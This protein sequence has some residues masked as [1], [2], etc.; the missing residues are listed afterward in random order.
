MSIRLTKQMRED[1]RDRVMAATT[2][3]V[4]RKEIE[5]ATKKYLSRWLS[6]QIPKAFRDFTKS[7]P[8]S[9]FMMA[10]LARVQNGVSPLYILMS[11]VPNSDYSSRYI[12]NVYLDDPVAKPADFSVPCISI[13]T[14][15]QEL[16]V[17]VAQATALHAQYTETK[18]KVEATLNGFTTLD[19]LIRE[20][21]EFEKHCTGYK[22]NYAVVVDSAN[23]LS[24]LFKAGFDTTETKPV[25][26]KAK[27][28]TKK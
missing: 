16:L 15:S 18:A 8:K 22:P 13:E 23:T 27:A 11:G 5:E 26:T 1:I 19:K 17:L 6:E 21:P 2:L 10:N 9:W 12:S 3:P 24:A 7:A 14:A 4:T 20:V 28:K 25:T